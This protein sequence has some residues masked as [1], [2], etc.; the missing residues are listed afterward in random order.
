[1]VYT[2]EVNTHPIGSCVSSLTNNF[3]VMTHSRFTETR[4]DK[5][6]GSHVEIYGAVGPNS[7]AYTV[8]VDGGTPAAFN[9]TKNSLH[10]QTLLYQYNEV[11]S[12]THTVNIS[13]TPFA[14]QTLSIDYA[15]IYG[16]STR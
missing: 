5:Q 2:F 11:V 9:G 8:Q 7:G 13:N 16:N 6:T 10:T 12:G 15:I 14:G 1:M 4:S 3:R